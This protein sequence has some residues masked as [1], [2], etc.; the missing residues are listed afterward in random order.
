[1][2][3]TPR[4]VTEL[5]DLPIKQVG[6]KTIYLRDLAQVSDGFALQTNVAGQD[7]HRGV[8]VSI[9]KAG[10]ASTLDVVAGIRK[11]LPRAALTLPPQ[12][13]ITP[14][15]DQ[16]LFVQSAISAAGTRRCP[17]RR[18]EQSFRRSQI[19][20]CIRGQDSAIF[21]LCWR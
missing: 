1:V 11:V 4:T 8:L 15:A 21:W 18:L 20:C 9:L 7:G 19:L 5:G 12:L 17:I 10:T 6:A 16:S 3:V 2:N 14:I 13:K